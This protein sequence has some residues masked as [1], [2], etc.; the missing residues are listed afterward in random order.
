MPL[1]LVSF[2][3]LGYNLITQLKSFLTKCVG[4][5]VSHAKPKGKAFYIILVCFVNT[6]RSTLKVHMKRNQPLYFESSTF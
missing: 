4:N 3:S 6:K 2:P 1:I 5:R